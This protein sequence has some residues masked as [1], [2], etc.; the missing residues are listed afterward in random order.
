MSEQH[1]GL[2]IPDPPGDLSAK[3]GLR[4][5][6][7]GDALGPGALAELGDEVRGRGSLFRGPFVSRHLPDDRDLLGIDSDVRGA[8]E[9]AA[10]LLG[11]PISYFVHYMITSLQTVGAR[12]GVA[13]SCV[14]R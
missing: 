9:Q 4:L 8:G 6:G 3:E 13:G 12:S 11:E 2:S 1:D 5:A 7:H 10:R 14:S